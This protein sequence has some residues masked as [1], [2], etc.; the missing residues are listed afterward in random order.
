[1]ATAMAM[2]MNGDDACGL[3]NSI[4]RPLCVSVFLGPTIDGPRLGAGRRRRRSG[5]TVPFWRGGSYLWILAD[6]WMIIFGVLNFWIDGF[7]LMVLIGVLRFADWN[8][9]ALW[10]LFRSDG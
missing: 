5:S 2:A 9:A 4:A 1:M 6:C 10:L 3:Y 8:P 7:G